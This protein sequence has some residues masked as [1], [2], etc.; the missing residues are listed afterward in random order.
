MHNSRKTCN[1][2]MCLEKFTD[3]NGVSATVNG[4]EFFFCSES[5]KDNALR[6]ML[7]AGKLTGF[8]EQMRVFVK[9]N[10]KII[11]MLAD[12]MITDRESELRGKGRFL[13]KTFYDCINSTAYNT[14]LFEQFMKEKEFSFK[15]GNPK[16]FLD[17]IVEY[18]DDF[19]MNKGFPMFFH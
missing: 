19:K 12:K 8:V 4:E 16:E 9:K 7:H 3:S 14:R 17:L 5:C 6:R 15:T 10:F 18:N 11:S 1:N 13:T 2:C